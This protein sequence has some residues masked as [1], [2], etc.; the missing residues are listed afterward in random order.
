MAETIISPGVFTRENDIS[1]IQPAPVAVGAAFIGPT[2]KGPVEEPTLVTS[3]NDYVRKFGVIFSSGSNKYEFLT[4]LAVKSYF[5]NGGRSALVSRV[6]AAGGGQT[7]QS[8]ESTNIASGLVLGQ[9]PASGSGTLTAAA[10]D[11]QQ[12][13]ITYSGVNYKF[14]ATDNPVPADVTAS[15]VYYFSTG[16][17]AVGTTDNLKSKINAVNIGFTAN[18]NSAL[19]QITASNNGTL[20]NS[21]TL[22]T[23]SIAGATPDSTL[24]TLGGGTDIAATSYPF[25]ISTIGKGV[26]YNS[27]NLAT[28]PG[29]QNPD[30]SL[31]SGSE[32]NLRWEVSNIN[33]NKGT[34]TLAIRRG[35]DNLK[36]KVVIETFNNLS[37][38]PASD[39]YIESRIGTQTTN[40]TTDSTST[41]LETVGEFPNRSNF[42][43][44]SA[45][46]IPTL[47]YLKNDGIGVNKDSAGLSYSAS[48]PLP[49]SG[50]FWNGTGNVIGG[51]NLFKNITAGNVQGLIGNDYNDIIALLGN[52]DDY[53]FN[54][55]TAPG[56]NAEDHTAQ[57]D[58]IISLA[59]DRGDCIAVVDLVGYDSNVGTVADSAANL[60]SSYAAAY[61]PW[62]QTRSATGKNEWIPAGVV[63]PGVYAFTD[64]AAAPWFAPAGLVRG[65]IPGVI[66]AER[67]LTKAERDTLYGSKVNPIASFPGTGIS[68]FGQ[69]T[70][71]TKASALDRVNVRRLL[72]ELKKFIG[73]QAKTLIFEQNTISTR[74]RFLATVNPY[75]ESVV[76]RQGLYAYRVIM[77]ET[78]NPADVVDRNQLIGQIFIQP[79]KTVEFV[80]LDFTIEP[81]GA[82]FA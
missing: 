74:N 72:I 75:L 14:I 29:T 45:V 44:V 9:N 10:A 73:D 63:I 56:L 31:V 24:I 27:T 52:K 47:N 16:S 8:A 41:Y 23:G 53:Q 4:S 3:Y 28:N 5:S 64:A 1:F 33:E 59:E 55:I 12:Y 39:D 13:W 54:V 78:N 61:W 34:F 69:K 60:N 18:V 15:Y 65:G 82:T 58:S 43:R 35:D 11:G 46:N 37:L 71:Q 22:K 79:A 40:I 20:Y 2:V 25:E 19:L 7:Y 80:V 6:V 51:A 68:V 30:G 67:R 66:Q 62:L 21:V 81:T 32:D 76:Q 38:D 49:Q 42:I 36:S 17:N 48:L 26:I 50:G 57:I 70:L 77:D